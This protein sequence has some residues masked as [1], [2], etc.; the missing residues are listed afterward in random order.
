MTLVEV[1]VAMS[2]GAI[3]VA[4][5][6]GVLST[7]QRTREQGEQRSDLF[8]SVR[9]ALARMERDLRV[10]VYRA[11]D[12]QFEFIGTDLTEGGLPADSI[13]FSSASGTPLTSLLP[14]GDLLRIQ[15]YIDVSEDTPQVGLVRQAMSL[16]LLEDIPPEE[17]ELAARGYC[18]T[19]VALDITYYDP[20]EQ[21][22]V[23]EWQERTDLPSSVRI[24]LYVLPEV[25]E[26]DEEVEATPESVMPF[27]TV[28]HLML[29]DAPLGEGQPSVTTAEAGPSGEEP[30]E[31]GEPGSE[32]LP[33]GGLPSLPG[34]AGGPP[35]MP[36]I[37]GGGA[38]R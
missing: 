1:L 32:N 36:T 34:G 5:V 30:P 20:T 31:A 11:D 14:T 23:E 37:P 26:E 17:E 10:A 25:P 2:I 24:V 3:V 21:T 4:A 19:A 16:P 28:V 33:E 29:A 9:V 18:P 38:T 7:A 6:L 35:E 22:W 27:S 12:P 15:Y 8:Q 13:E